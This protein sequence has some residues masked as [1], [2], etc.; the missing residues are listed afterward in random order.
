MG[1]KRFLAQG[2]PMEVFA[3]KKIKKWTTR[4]KERNIRLVEAVGVSPA[5]EMIYVWSTSQSPLILTM[6]DSQ[7]NDFLLDGYRRMDQ[8]N[9]QITLEA[10]QW[11]EEEMETEPIDE[12]AIRWVLLSVVMRNVGEWEKAREYIR[13]TLDAEKRIIKSAMVNDY[14]GNRP[15]TTRVVPGNANLGQ[16][17][18]HTMSER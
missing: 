14:M 4:A 16:C 17:R 9:F 6:R 12:Q 3:D 11:R 18:R 5:E 15:P 7:T 2:L 1:K 8:R 10:L 13:K